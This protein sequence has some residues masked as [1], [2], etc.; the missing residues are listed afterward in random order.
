MNR[1]GYLDCTTTNPH[2]NC[3]PKLIFSTK[4]DFIALTK[5]NKIDYLSGNIDAHDTA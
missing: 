3:S 2:G 4:K 5:K 1:V